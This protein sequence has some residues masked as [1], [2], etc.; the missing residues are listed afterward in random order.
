MLVAQGSDEEGVEKI[1][2]AVA[3]ESEL[4][5]DFGPPTIVKPSL[6]LLGDVLMKLDRKN[7]AIEAYNKQ[8]ERTPDRRKSLNGKEN[9]T[10]LTLY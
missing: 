3:A 5:I 7:E 8:L 9:A 4:P 10:A 1:Q 6:E 2:S